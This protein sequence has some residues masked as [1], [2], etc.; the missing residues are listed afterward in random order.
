MD[1]GGLDKVDMEPHQYH[2]ISEV[3]VIRGK[4]CKPFLVE[5]VL[6]SGARIICTSEKLARRSELH[7]T[8][9]RLVYS[10]PGLNS[11]TVVAGRKVTVTPQIRRLQLYGPTP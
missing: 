7:F 11:V 9:E 2:R 4:A 10:F 1:A 5:P 6:D 3:L 8:D